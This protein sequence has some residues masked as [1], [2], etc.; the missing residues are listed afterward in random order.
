M[1]VKNPFVESI[2]AEELIGQIKRQLEAKYDIQIDL[3]DQ[4]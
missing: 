4:A 2:G 3:G 1:T